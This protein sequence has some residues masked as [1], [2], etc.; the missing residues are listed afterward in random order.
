MSKL[1]VWILITVAATTAALL[2]TLLRVG[3]LRSELSE[4]NPSTEEKVNFFHSST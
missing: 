3:Q 1:D 2:W 4:L